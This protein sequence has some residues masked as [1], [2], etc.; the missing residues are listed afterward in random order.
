ML[1]RA[2]GILLSWAKRARSGSKFCLCALSYAWQMNWCFEFLSTHS[3]RAWNADSKI[4]FYKV[5]LWK[6]DESSVEFSSFTKIW[7][8][9]WTQN[10]RRDR[11]HIARWWRFKWRAVRECRLEVEYLDRELFKL[12]WKSLGPKLGEV[13]LAWDRDA[14][15]VQEWRLSAR[16]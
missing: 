7:V 10:R 5:C 3:H 13:S 16:G 14:T 2:R 8:H 9:I 12:M 6:F 15:D 11:T 1:L 4:Y